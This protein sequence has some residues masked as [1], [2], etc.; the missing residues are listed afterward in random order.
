LEV[1]KHHSWLD[2]SNDRETTHTGVKEGTASIKSRKIG[3]RAPEKE[4]ADNRVDLG[5]GFKEG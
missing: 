5:F 2:R 3:E 4:E 1:E